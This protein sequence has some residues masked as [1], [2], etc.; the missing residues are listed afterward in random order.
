M[1]LRGLADQSYVLQVPQ[2]VQ[3]TCESLKKQFLSL[4]R[5]LCWA[6]CTEEFGWVTVA[7]LELENSA[8]ILS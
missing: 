5:V 4:I 2:V 6:A 3:N 1:D 8:E 7:E